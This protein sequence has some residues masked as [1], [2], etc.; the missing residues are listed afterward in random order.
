MHVDALVVKRYYCNLMQFAA[1]S[2]K[3]DVFRNAFGYPQI[4][5]LVLSSMA[6]YISVWPD[7]FFSIPQV[8][9]E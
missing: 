7:H 2:P 5:A 9:S 6:L 8:L 4:S 1:C 3:D